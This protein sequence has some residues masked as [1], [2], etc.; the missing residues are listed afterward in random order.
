MHFTSETTAD[1]IIE[2]RFTIGDVPGALWSP[3]AAAADAPLVLSGHPGGLHMLVPAVMR[4]A[5]QLVGARGFHVAAIDAP[6]HGDRPRSEEDAAWVARMQAAREAGEPLGPIVSAFNGSLAERAV[7]EW[8]EIIDALLDE[9][10]PVPVGYRG[11]TLGTEIGARLI[12][13]DDR[14]RV[15]VLGAAFASDALMD[16][17]RRITVPVTYLLP[18]DDREID[19]ESGIALFGALGSKEKR[20]VAFS[21]PHQRVPWS[22][23]EEAGAF[24]ARHLAG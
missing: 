11:M 21:E 14:I 20:M 8:R 13:A 7:P 15:A 4:R 19:R 12:A 9:L 17:M 16:A 24:L 2:R 22:E 23:V 10:G 3:V 1:G 5:I 6:G 18:W